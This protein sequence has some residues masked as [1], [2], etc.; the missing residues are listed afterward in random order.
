MAGALEAF[1]GPQKREAR[2]DRTIRPALGPARSHTGESGPGPIA[3][4]GC[5]QQFFFKKS[6]DRDSPSC[7]L[8]LLHTDLY[9]RWPL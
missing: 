8:R 2:R 7:F 6:I 5:K 1:R 9:R 4:G 3:E